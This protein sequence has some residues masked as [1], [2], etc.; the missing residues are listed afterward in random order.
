MV[1]VLEIV[2]YCR[3]VEHGLLLERWSS[4]MQFDQDP[5]DSDYL[6]GL[7]CYG[8]ALVKLVYFVDS[9]G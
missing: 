7:C 1:E 8:A 9:A 2:F 6:R 4:L 5:S 3:R